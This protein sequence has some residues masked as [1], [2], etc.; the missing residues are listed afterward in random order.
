MKIVFS[1]PTHDTLPTGN[2]CTANQ[3]GELLRE[4]G[5][6][7]SI[8]GIENDREAPGADLLI[9]LHGEQSLPVIKHSRET[10]PDRPIILAVTGTDIYPE[11]NETVRESL[12]LVDRIVVLQ[13]N[14]LKQIPATFLPKTHV[15]F[16]SAEAFPG[17]VNKATDFFDVCVVGHLRDVKDPMRAAVATRNLPESSRIRI[18]HAGGVLDEKYRELITTEQAENPRYEWL[19]SLSEEEVA[20]LIASSRLMVISSLSE[21]GARVV[22]ESIVNGTPVISSAIAG[23]KGLLGD[24]Y[25]GYFPVRETSSLTSLL[26]RAETD[27]EFF[28]SLQQH[29]ADL[30]SR[31]QPEV[32]MESWKDLLKTLG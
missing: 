25:P 16:Q 5:H 30:A 12:R 15:I 8:Q 1:T 26:N 11:P 23:V 29:I 28:S 17:D 22:G 6:E 10:A 20:G 4:L 14:A 18:H 24:D 3:W 21:G 7:V 31:F 19:G 13:A 32:E 2:L 27:P 9:T